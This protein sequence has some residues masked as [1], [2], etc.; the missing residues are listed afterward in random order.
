MTSRAV[1]VATLLTLSVAIFLASGLLP[2]D[3]PL[4]AG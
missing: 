4:L 3:A 2:T 1:A